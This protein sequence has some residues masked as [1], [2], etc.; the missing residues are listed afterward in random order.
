[1]TG[2]SGF[3]G[4]AVVSELLERGVAVTAAVRREAAFPPQ[5][6]AVRVGNIDASTDW[7]AAIKGCDTIVHCAA[8]VH[9]MQ[10]T[11]S[12]PLDEF[13]ATNVH[14][15]LRLANQASGAGVR[16]FIFI[17]SVK[18][19]G[20]FTLPDAPFTE[21]DTPAPA[22][23]YGVSKWE[24]EQ[25]LQSVA[26]ERGLE[27]VIVRPPLVYGPGVRANF[28]SMSRWLLRGI[29]LPFASVTSNRRSLVA[30]D[31]LVDLILA[32]ANRS[33]AAGETFLAGDGDD[34]STA[35]LLRRTATALGVRARLL[36]VPE[37]VLAR[38][39]ALLG[40][41]DLWQRLGGSLQ[42]STRHA[43]ATL[44]WKPPVTVDEGL[45]RAVADL[46]VRM[47]AE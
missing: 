7:T 34:L 35:E 29:P 41:A 20:E 43:C 42:V 39:A 11:A 45:R 3:V 37:S 19:N 25:R 36:P 23:P 12:D 6:V 2:A 30:L 9:V 21:R 16:R 47:A 15:T 31:N 32:C 40:R 38:G 1:V 28:L 22:G 24:A 27:L 18:V 8:R 17:S 13:R 26:A 44:D 5:C 14:G 4:R 33:A 10:E 46:R